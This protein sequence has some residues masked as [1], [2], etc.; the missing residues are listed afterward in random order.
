MS[1]N[2]QSLEFIEVTKF[3]ASPM[4]ESLLE[5]P[6]PMRIVPREW[7]GSRA[8]LATSIDV[9]G[10]E[11][12]RAQHAYYRPFE[13][14]PMEIEDMPAAQK[15][16]LAVRDARDLIGAA[17]RPQYSTPEKPEMKVAEVMYLRP[18]FD[19]VPSY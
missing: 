1:F 3:V 8:S 16:S 12:Q 11:P 15:L 6:K 4:E 13:P 18:G 17:Q 5:K 7:A 2:R 19:N 10:Q 14:D 9:S